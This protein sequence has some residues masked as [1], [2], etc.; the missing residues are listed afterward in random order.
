MICNINKILIP[1]ND[2]SVSLGVPFTHTIEG[3]KGQVVLTVDNKVLFIADNSYKDIT[4][5]YNIAVRD[6]YKKC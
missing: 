1:K 4:T 5:N 6:N 2:T 3:Q